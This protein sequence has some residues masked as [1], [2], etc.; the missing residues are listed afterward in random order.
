MVNLVNTHNVTDNATLQLGGARN[1]ATAV[2]GGTHY[3][4]VGGTFDPFGSSGLSVF[5]V[6]VRRHAHQRL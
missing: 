5:S 4:I 6:G 1:V 2:I 3:L